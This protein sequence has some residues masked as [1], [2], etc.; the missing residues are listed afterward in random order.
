MVKK[1]PVIVD[2]CVLLDIFNDDPKWYA[3]SS[4]TLFECSKKSQPAINIIIF[5]EVAFNFDS[6]HHLE[7]TLGGLGIEILAIPYEAAFSVSRAFKQ[8]RQNKGDRK[9]PMLD[10]YIGAHALNLA[11]SLITRDTARFTTYFPDLQLITPGT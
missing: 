6:S 9:T 2:A 3:W 5:T 7:Q 4:E 8:Y 10:F 11:A 1:T